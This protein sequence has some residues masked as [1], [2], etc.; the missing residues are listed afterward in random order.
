M[1]K[2]I[3]GGSPYIRIA[4]AFFPCV[5]VSHEICGIGIENTSKN[6]IADLINK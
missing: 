2:D 5:W 4:H 3:V 1:F 6:S